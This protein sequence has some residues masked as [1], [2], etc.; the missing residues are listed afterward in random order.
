MA[1]LLDEVVIVDVESTCWQGNPPEGQTSDII[2]IGVC[3]LNVRSGERSKKA[4]L[5]VRPQR[6]TVSDFCTELTTLTQAQVERG[7]CFADACQKLRREYRTKDRVWASYG[8]YDR[9]QFE[10]Q[11]QETGVSYPFGTGHIN[12]KTLFALTQ[13]LHKELGMAGALEHLNL[14]LEGTH[15]RGIDDAWNIALILWQILSRGR[16]VSQNS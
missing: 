3:L 10:R 9:K 1:K 6:S 15:H 2:E 7:L 8:D 12:V 11:C 4:G 13:P 16:G 5:L 14:P